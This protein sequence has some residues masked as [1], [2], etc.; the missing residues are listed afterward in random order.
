MKNILLLIIILIFSLASCSQKT[1]EIV[2]EKPIE[3]VSLLFMGDIMGHSPQIN[4]AY[5]KVTKKYNYDDVFAKVA[6]I[7]QS[8][9]FAIAN[10]EVTLAGKPYKGYPQFSSPNALA[11][12][13]KKSGIDVLVTSN[14]HSCDRG[15]K[16][17]LRTIKTLDSLKI[18]HT[19]TFKDSTERANNNLLVL[20]K[21][22]IKIGIL[23]YTYG[24]NGMPIPKPTLVNLIDKEQMLVDITASKKDSLDKLI[25]FIHWGN[26]YKTKP[27]TAQE[28]T[29]KYLFDNG[30][31]IIIGSH[32]HVL[33]RMEYIQADEKNKEKLIAYSLG[34]FV[35]NQRKIDR[36]GGAMLRLT[37][38]K[39]ED[40]ISIS[41]YGYYLVWVDKTTID[42][43][44]KYEIFPCSYY[45]G[46]GFF[47]MDSISKKNMDIFTKNSR[48]LLKADNI[49]IKEIK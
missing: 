31:D 23:N 30:V 26:E 48:K 19:G 47:S 9:D 20:H 34:N 5:N 45:T 4:A 17:I 27:S 49:L 42:K 13:C 22:N 8:V 3:S 21:N 7:I 15:K 38:S 39:K 41:D 10:L 32:P 33:Q 36:D 43:K 14:N 11:N 6:P 35:S 2:V 12:A 37:L 16:G 28:E 29:A 25:V 1:K 18:K 40:K 46:N 44:N 24:T